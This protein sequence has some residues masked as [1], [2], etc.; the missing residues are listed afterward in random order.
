MAL[1]LFSVPRRGF[2]FAMGAHRLRGDARDL[3]F[4]S[5]GGID[6]RIHASVI[7]FALATGALPGYDTRLE[8]LLGFVVQLV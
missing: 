7:S 6:L 8:T 2:G 5:D 4:F 3:Y 1:P